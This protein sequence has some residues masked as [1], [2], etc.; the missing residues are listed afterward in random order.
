M[1]RFR[2]S[3]LSSVLLIA[4]MGLIVLILVSPDVDLPDTAFLRNGS[5]LV[6][7]AGSHHTSELNARDLSPRFALQLEDV[8]A[9]VCHRGQATARWYEGPSQQHETL[10]C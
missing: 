7:H 3:P 9:L 1:R 5:R 4:L 10:R 6:I 2:L 8:S